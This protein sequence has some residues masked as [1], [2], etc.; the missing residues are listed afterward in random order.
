MYFLR[1]MIALY[2]YYDMP[3]IQI[4]LSALY[5][6]CIDTIMTGDVCLIQY[7]INNFIIGV[8]NISE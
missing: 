1:G 8:H 5:N 6:Y 7:C 4:I 2:N 3:G